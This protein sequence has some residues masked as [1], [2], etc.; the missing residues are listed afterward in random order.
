MR[1]D[2]GTGIAPARMVMKAVRARLLEGFAWAILLGGCG[3]VATD[4]AETGDS[5]A[6]CA[7]GAFV[8]VGSI[9]TVARSRD[10]ITWDNSFDAGWQTTWD[11]VAYESGRLVAL[12]IAGEVLTSVDAADWQLGSRSTGL[13]AFDLQSAGNELLAAGAT[14]ETR[15]AVVLRSADAENWQPM[16]TPLPN[17]FFAAIAPHEGVI[18]AVA[19][20]FT[21]D[22]QGRRQKALFRAEAGQDWELVVP[23]SSEPGAML[24]DVTYGER[25][26]AVG[27]RVVATSSD[28]RTWV[29]SPLEA[30]FTAVGFG[31]DRYVAVGFDTSATSA[32]AMSWTLAPLRP[33][34]APPEI[35]FAM[36]AIAYGRCRFF[37]VGGPEGWNATSH[38]GATW[39]AGLGPTHGSFLE[40]VFVPEL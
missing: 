35:R 23:W 28:G 31:G 33:P 12:G 10:G 17:G 29:A 39:T 24:E 13:E 25:F 22:A 38:D 15:Q 26:V 14:L 5:G 16:G 20:V 1:I 27:D 3:N 7:Q 34:H 32:D 30:H 9:G 40:V 4:T 36:E 6:E 18:V 19:S 2:A 11:G 8:A 21:A 37:A